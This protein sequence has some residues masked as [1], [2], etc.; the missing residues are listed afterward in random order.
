MKHAYFI[1]VLR[2][3]NKVLKKQKKA[4][5]LVFVFIVIVW[6]LLCSVLTVFMVIGT[7]QS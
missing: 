1:A 4:D 5:F 6:C 3:K 2:C 7:L